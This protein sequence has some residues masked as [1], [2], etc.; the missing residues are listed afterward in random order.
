MTPILFVLAI[1]M[2]ATV[3]G[4]TWGVMTRLAGGKGSASEIFYNFFMAF[5]SFVAVMFVW[6]VNYG[7]PGLFGFGAILACL[8]VG[9]LAEN[10]S[11]PWG[12]IWPNTTRDGEDDFKFL[13]PLIDYTSGVTYSRDMDAEALVHW[14][15][16]AWIVRDTIYSIPTAAV[17]CVASKSILPI[18]IFALMSLYRGWI[19]RREIIVRQEGGKPDPIAKAEVKQGFFRGFFRVISLLA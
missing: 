3:S 9:V 15:L 6:T 10:R 13:K 2:M 16:S 5:I 8:I 4:L 19:Y 14:R 11:D 17:F 1:L 18:F 7:T 12:E